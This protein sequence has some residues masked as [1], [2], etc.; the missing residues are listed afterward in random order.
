MSKLKLHEVASQDIGR[1]RSPRGRRTVAVSALH[2]KVTCAL[3]GLRLVTVFLFAKARRGRWLKFILGP[4]GRRTR[5]ATPHA[6]V[7]CRRARRITPRASHFAA[8][9][10]PATQR[11]ASPSRD[12]PLSSRSRARCTRYSRLPCCGPN[13]NQSTPKLG[14]RTLFASSIPNGASG[15]R[16]LSCSLQRPSHR[17]QP[18]RWPRGRLRRLRRSL[19]IWLPRMSSRRPRRPRTPAT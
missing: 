5:S 15:Q 13:G 11:P 9:I 8:A 17:P 10:T 19:R 12:D 6:D 1:L 16:W 2:Q 4:K 18:Q 14:R 7:A 3:W